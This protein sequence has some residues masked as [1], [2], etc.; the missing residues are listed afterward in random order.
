MISSGH[1]ARTSVATA[2][3]AF[4][5]WD[6]SIFILMKRIEDHLT[7]SLFEY[8]NLSKDSLLGNASVALMEEKQ[9]GWIPFESSDKKSVGEVLI[10]SSIHKKIE[11]PNHVINES[12]FGLFG[13]ER[14][15]FSGLFIVH[16]V[17]AKELKT[18][19]GPIINKSFN[20]YCEVSLNDGEP[21]KSRVKRK[22]DQPE[23]NEQF[24]FIVLN[25]KSSKLMITLREQKDISTNNVL[26]QVNIPLISILS[27]TEK[28]LMKKIIFLIF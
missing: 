13:S 22:S 6:E 26:G 15:G 20:S 11:D 7:L 4:A 24:E 19:A 10:E 9:I 28:V 17:E 14:V 25:V 18:R 21:F 3:D 2:S 23:W 1:S 5:T 27:N 16:V 12:K 8:N